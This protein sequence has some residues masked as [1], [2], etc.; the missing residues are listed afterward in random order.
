MSEFLTIAVTAAKKAGKVLLDN[1]NTDTFGKN[2]IKFNN[3]ISIYQ[4]GILEKT[5]TPINNKN[6]INKINLESEKI[7]INLIKKKFPKH[8][9]YSKNFKPNNKK[10]EFVWCVDPL[11]G[12]VNFLRGMSLFGISIG[13]IK[14]K[15]P[16]VG[17]LYL[18]AL[19]LLVCA[20]K[21]KGAYA[22]GKR[23]NVSNRSIENSLYYTRGKY[24]NVLR[25][26][27][28]IFKK[29]GFIKIIDCSCF[30]LA[31]IAM[32]DAELYAMKSVPY[33]ACAG[34]VVVREAGGKVTDFNGGNWTISSKKVIVSNGIIHDD[35]LKIVNNKKQK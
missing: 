9:I 2:K 3:D 12:T 28:K 32:G 33:D 5:K 10:S 34:I 7:I 1:Y 22:N 14:D 4:A 35:I 25:M 16:I 30:E 26:N 8:E 24:N 27:W 6:L 11:D 31:K 20:E 23:I 19:D 21:G 17:V 15:V 18:P 29:I 13:L